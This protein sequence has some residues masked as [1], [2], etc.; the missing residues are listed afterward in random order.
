MAVPR[1]LGQVE[2]T[3]GIE[4]LAE[5]LRDAG[6]QVTVHPFE[7][8]DPGTDQ[9]HALQNL[10]G[11]VR[12]DAPRQFVLASHFDVRPWAEEDSDPAARQAPIP[13][14]N[15][16]TSGVAL[17]LAL[18]EVL[19]GTL[20]DDVGFTVALFDGEELGRP[21]LGGYCAGSKAFAANPQAAPAS[22]RRASFGVVLD[23][24]GDADL[25]VAHEPHSQRQH[26]GLSRVIWQVAARLGESA[27]RPSAYA[28]AIIDDHIYLTQAGIPSVLL[29]DYDYPAWHTHR[30][31][32]D[33]VSGASLQTVARVVHASLVQIA[34]SE[35]DLF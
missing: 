8:I 1:T 12:P 22:M 3:T 27:F 18:A 19:R 10:Y 31:D 35:P 21:G 20:P 32:I 6:T 29:I 5:A 30:D 4:T 13:G 17:A 14:A 25:A 11:T 16:G 2:R 9:R 34:T 7:A 15:D 33:R 23:M 28:H 24:V 26:P